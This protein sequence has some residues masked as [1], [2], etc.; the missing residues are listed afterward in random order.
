MAWE[1]GTT[2]RPARACRL[3]T[4]KIQTRGAGRQER[5]GLSD[6]IAG[7]QGRIGLL[8]K[9]AGPQD[10]IGLLGK[11]AGPWDR[12]GLPGKRTGPSCRIGLLRSRAD[13]R[14]KDGHLHT[15]GPHRRDQLPQPVELRQSR[16]RAK[17][18]ARETLTGKQPGA[19]SRNAGASW[20]QSRDERRK[21]S[22]E[23]IKASGAKKGAELSES[24]HLLWRQRFS[25]YSFSYGPM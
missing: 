20:K 11:T 13:P 8:P 3:D 19:G 17:E 4:I 6:K 14:A 21:S 22:S 12:A 10:R 25:Y 15:E 24:E 23:S 16:A 1:Q 5:V 2:A 7:L 18:T 9:T